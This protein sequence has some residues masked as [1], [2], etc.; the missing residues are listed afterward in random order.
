MRIKEK[1][2]KLREEAQNRKDIDLKVREEEQNIKELREKRKKDKA[3]K[4]I[5]QEE[6]RMKEIEYIKIREWEEKFDREQKIKEQKELRREQKIKDQELKRLK[7]IEE[8]ENLES[9]LKS[10]LENFEI[11]KTSEH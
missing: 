10:G 9:P 4:L 7:V 1:E 2:L 6:D 3:L 8:N 5:K 11:D